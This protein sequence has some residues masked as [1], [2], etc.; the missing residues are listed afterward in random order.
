[1]FRG[2]SKMPNFARSL[3]CSIPRNSGISTVAAS[4]LGVDCIPTPLNVLN[5]HEQM[6]KEAGV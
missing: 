1:M 4:E 5:D 2:L 6:M 3:R